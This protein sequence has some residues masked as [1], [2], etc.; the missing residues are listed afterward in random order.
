MRAWMIVA[1]L[2]AGGPALAQDCVLA[3]T[4]VLYEPQKGVGQCF[5]LILKPSYLASERIGADTI[6]VTDNDR[7][8]AVY[9]HA[10]ESKFGQWARVMKNPAAA[11]NGQKVPAFTVTGYPKTGSSSR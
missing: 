5:E 1:G 11:V 4:E 3:S 7:V 2:L 10:D 8:L 9:H 6:A